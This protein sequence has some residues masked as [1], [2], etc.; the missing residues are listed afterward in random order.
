MAMCWLA[1]GREPAKYKRAL[2][3]AHFSLKIESFSALSSLDKDKYDSEVFKAGGYR[4]SLSLYPN[5]N[6]KDNGS[7]YISL[8]LSIEERDKLADGLKVHINYKLF[9]YNKSRKEYLT[10]QDAEGAVSSFHRSKTQRGF[11]R[12]LS[13][14]KLKK[15]GYLEGDSC[16]FGAEVFVIQP[17]QLREESFTLTK[18]PTQ[19]THTWNIQGWSTLGTRR[20]SN[21]FT[22][23]GR[24]W[25]LLVDPKGN[26]D[27]KEKSM[28]VYLEVQ[29]LTGKMKVYAEFSLRVL[30]QLK[31]K[32]KDHEF[33]CWLSASHPRGGDANFM[34]L[35]D[36]LKKSGK[37]F[38]SNDTLIVEVQFSIISA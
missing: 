20:H 9:V 30:D 10:I 33:K 38:V 1:T 17:A 21:E 3:P 22:I 18:Y 7:G 29:R 36:L 15:D 5:G 8:Y 26:T 35:R 2:P 24:Q 32:H 34:P 31:N 12:F 4:W 23:E 28:S 6:K 14:K 25:K 27:S 11:P 13:L 16:T 19:R 37:G